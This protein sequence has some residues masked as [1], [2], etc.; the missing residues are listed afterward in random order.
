MIHLLHWIRKCSFACKTR[1]F[2][3]NSEMK[4]IR[5]KRRGEE[6]CMKDETLSRLSIYSQT[7]LGLLRTITMQQG[8]FVLQCTDTCFFQ[9]DIIAILPLFS[10]WATSISVASLSELSEAKSAFPY[11]LFVKCWSTRCSWGREIIQLA[12][13]KRLRPPLYIMC[14]QIDRFSVNSWLQHQSSI[15]ADSN[16]LILVVSAMS[17]ITSISPKTDGKSRGRA[18]LN[19]VAYQNWWWCTH[20]TYRNLKRAY[21]IKYELSQWA[22]VWEKEAYP[23]HCEHRLI[24]VSSIFFTTLGWKRL[25][26]GRSN[27]SL[28]EIGAGN[29]P[30]E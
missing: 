25:F 3:R 13:P 6:R 27:I 20:I 19:V 24:T 26:E 18:T 22:K 10:I 1:D 4:K 23:V 11:Q 29:L 7:H 14:H 16:K 30:L 21:W 5:N 8:P 17:N 15:Q 2:T 9:A 12:Q 28:G